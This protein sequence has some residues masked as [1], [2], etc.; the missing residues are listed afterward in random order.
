MGDGCGDAWVTDRVTDARG[1]VT[2][3]VTLPLPPLHTPDLRV[4]KVRGLP[5][6]DG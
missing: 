5:G 2:R 1:C 4:W 3:C 6:I